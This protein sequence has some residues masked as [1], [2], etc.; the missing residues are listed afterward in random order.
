MLEKSL[1]PAVK[2]APLEIETSTPGAGVPT[3]CKKNSTRLNANEE[4]VAMTLNVTARSRT[5]WT[6]SV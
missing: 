3:S 6:T 5:E 2:L 4:F 1:L